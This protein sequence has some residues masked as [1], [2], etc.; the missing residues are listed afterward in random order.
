MWSIRY[1]SML[2]LVCLLIHHLLP[3]CDSF[4]PS[5]QDA[6]AHLDMWLSSHWHDPYPTPEEKQGL[7]DKCYITVDQVSIKAMCALV[8]CGESFL[9]IFTHIFALFVSFCPA[10][11][12][13][14]AWFRT[15]ETTP[16]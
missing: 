14:F 13:T 7:A 1:V 3:R 6:R 2:L 10:S 5:H 16:R 9:R 15:L 4:L 12:L 8:F 11:V